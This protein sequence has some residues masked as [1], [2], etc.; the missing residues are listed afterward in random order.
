M[1]GGLIRKMMLGRSQVLGEK[2]RQA[3]SKLQPSTTRSKDTYKR[4]HDDKII[5]SHSLDGLAS[6]YQSQNHHGSRQRGCNDSRC[7]RIPAEIRLFVVRF[8]SHTQSKVKGSHQYVFG[9]QLG[10]KR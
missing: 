1:D 3:R 5:K 9:Q 2:T 4:H 10:N 8:R 7:E 6:Y